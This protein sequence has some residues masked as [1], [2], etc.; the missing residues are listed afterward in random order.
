MWQATQ[1]TTTPWQQIVTSPLIRCAAFAE[2]LGKSQA[3][4]VTCDARLRE[5][6]FG[7]WENQSAAD[8]LQTQADALTQFWQNPLE[9]PPPQGEHL[10]D[11]QARVLAAWHEISIRL[12]GQHILLIAHGGVIRVIRCHLQ[13]HPIE[14][15]LDFD[16]GHAHIFR[17]N[18]EPGATTADSLS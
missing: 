15:L 10:L 1:Q 17:V 5:I 9:F 13:Q 14:R 4:P 12:A 3:I 8:L 16:V 2:S 18:I 7:V 11:F 6:H